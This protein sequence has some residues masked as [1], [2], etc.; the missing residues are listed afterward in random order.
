MRPWIVLSTYR[1]SAR[2]T[3]WSRPADL[4]PT[5]YA[6]SV[7]RAGGVAMLAPVI[8]GQAEDVRA[9]PAALVLTG[10]PDVDPARYGAV[11]HAQ[12]DPPRPQRDDSEIALLEAALAL[13]RPVLAI[14]RGVQ[15]LN[16]AI[17]GGLTQHLPDAGIEHRDRAGGFSGREVRIEAGSR[18]A[19]VLGTSARVACSHHQ[20]LDRLGSGLL[21]VAWAD[22]ATVEAVE[23]AGHHWVVG[24]QWHPEEGDDLRLFEA[25]VAAAAQLVSLP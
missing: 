22:D 25:L 12:T 8:P 5:S 1:E 23:L 9:A 17:G 4:L 16:V 21:P 13:Q 20:A 3:G 10:G 24:V 11:A 19:D 14:C 15:V 2:W 6:D 18:L 7:E